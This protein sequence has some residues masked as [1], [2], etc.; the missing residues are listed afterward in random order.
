MGGI[1]A[2][3]FAVVSKRRHKGESAMP[4][5]FSLFLIQIFSSFSAA[6][7]CLFCILRHLLYH[8]TRS[9]YVTLPTLMFFYFLLLLLSGSLSP[10]QTPSN[11][12]N[13]PRSEKDPLGSSLSRG[14]G[15]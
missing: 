14:N 7:P 15:L 5:K 6:L 4:A 1:N 8:Q 13:L 12:S 11:F 3:L 10:T 2:V 9:K